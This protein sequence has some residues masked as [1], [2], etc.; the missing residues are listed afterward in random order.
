M[1]KGS[2]T[3]H[4]MN[5]FLYM[6]IYFFGSILIIIES[7]EKHPSYMYFGAGEE[8]QYKLEPRHVH[9]SIK[10][11]KQYLYILCLVIMG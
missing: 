9:V 5:F 1:D 10:W 3:Y 6:T 7:E 2:G 4:H 8:Y 11:R